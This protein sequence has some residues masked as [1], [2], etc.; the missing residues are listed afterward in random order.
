[1]P[2]RNCPSIYVPPAPVVVSPPHLVSHAARPTPPNMTGP[3]QLD[4]PRGRVST[5]LVPMAKK[6]LLGKMGGSTRDKSARVWH[7]LGHKLAALKTLKRKKLLD[8]VERGSANEVLE[9]LD[10][11]ADV[12]AKNALGQTALHVAAARGHHHVVSV[13][14]DRGALVNEAAMDGSSPLAAACEHGHDIVA[15]LLL[16]H[17]A[18]PDAP[19]LNGLAPIHIA[20]RRG[21]RGLVQLLLKHKVRYDAPVR[22]SSQTALMMACATGMSELAEL[23]LDA[24]A[25]PHAEDQDGNTPLHFAVSDGNYRSTYLLLTAGADPDMPNAREETAFDLADQ[26]GHAHIQYLLE[27]NGMGAGDQTVD[28]LDQAFVQDEQLS[29]ALA[30]NRPE[31][32][33]VIVKN[34][35][36]YA[37]FFALGSLTEDAPVERF[38]E[39]EQLMF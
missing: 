25:D 10:A 2:F 31:L 19:A 38:Q 28:E 29:E 27:T 16:K 8:V 37:Q 9:A 3:V 22:S 7:Y 30:R 4:G 17:K 1:M 34:R 23:L 21:Q 33:D 20:T 26:N 14:L 15:G 6:P 24:G 35:L 5:A 11:G 12:N 36:K 32:A 39:R 18:R 13:L